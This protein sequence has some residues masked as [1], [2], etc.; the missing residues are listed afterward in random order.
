MLDNKRNRLTPIYPS[1]LEKPSK[2]TV[3]KETQN[4]DKEAADP[5]QDVDKE[6]GLFW[7]LIFEMNPN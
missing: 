5:D 4:H 3:N 6:T 1:S 2:Q 7:I